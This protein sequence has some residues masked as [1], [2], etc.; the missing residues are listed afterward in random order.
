MVQPLVRAWA[1]LRNRAGGAH[2]PPSPAWRG[3]RLQWLLEL[4]RQLVARRCT[5]RWGTATDAWDFQASVGPFVSYKVTTA[6]VWSWVPQH[7][8]RLNIR[9]TFLATAALGGLLLTWIPAAGIVVLSGGVL[10]AA[11][12]A[13][14]LSMIL[15]KSI[16]ATSVPGQKSA[17]A[18][19]SVVEKAVA[20]A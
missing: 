10:L 14:A 2:P 12:E 11:A 13:V 7:S 9:S 18:P 20:D 3:D 19:G 6:V 4:R 8:V 17:A 15:K 16:G 1:R 5:I